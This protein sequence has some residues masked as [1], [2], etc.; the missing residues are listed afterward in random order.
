MIRSVN[1]HISIEAFE[2]CP[3]STTN[4]SSLGPKPFLCPGLPVLVEGTARGSRWASAWARRGA[5]LGMALGQGG[6]SAGLHRAS[7]ESSGASSV[8]AADAFA[9]VREGWQ[10]SPI[11]VSAGKAVGARI[12]HAGGS[13]GFFPAPP[14]PGADRL[15]LHHRARSW[16][17]EILRI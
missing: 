5:P 14:P 1:I 16:K 15:S 11:A 17:S 13:V 3:I 12:E 9:Q 10:K 4:Q 6:A 2:L 7:G 8:A